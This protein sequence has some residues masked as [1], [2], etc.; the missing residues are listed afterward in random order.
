MRISNYIDEI[1]DELWEVNEYIHNNPELGYEEYKTHARL[2]SFML[3]KKEWRVTKSAYGMDTAWVA[4]Y[5]REG[6]GPVVSFNVEMG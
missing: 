2:T 6:D 5:D 4:V 1:S 3:S